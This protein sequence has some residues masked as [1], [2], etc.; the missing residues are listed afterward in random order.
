M[1][2]IEQPASPPA[3]STRLAVASDLARIAR[4]HKAAYSRS[5]FTALLSEEVLKRYYGSFLSDGTEIR[6]ALEAGAGSAEIARGFSVYGVGIPEKI[7]AFKKACAKDILLTSL[8][9]PRLS[10]RKAL[11]AVLAKLGSRPA[12]P[13]ADFLLLSI[14]VDH[15]A[16][17]IG[18]ELLK[19]MMASARQ[20][21]HEIAGLYVNEDNIRAINAYFATGFRMKDFRDGQYYMEAATGHQASQ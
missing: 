18:K 21:G 7:A 4:I 8:R 3:F 20:N 16:T 12:H 17:G 1:S 2:K 5:H 10:A 15:P 19:D 6:L 9:H 11:K 13:A 14:A